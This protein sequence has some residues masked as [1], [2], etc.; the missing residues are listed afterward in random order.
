MKVWNVSEKEIYRAAVNTDV[1]IYNMRDNG[2]AKR[3][4]LKLADCKRWQRTSSS[5]FNR[6]RKVAVV[7]WHGHYHFMREIFRIN[8]DARIQTSWA[9]YKGL[10]SFLTDAPR[11]GK[12]NIGPPID[13]LYVEDACLCADRGDDYITSEKATENA[14][15]HTVMRAMDI[16]A[17]PHFIMTPEHYRSNGEC[18][19]DDPIEQD[20]LIRE[21][22]YIR[23]D[24]R[25]AS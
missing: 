22:G 11:T 1:R 25:R 3:F 23:E 12:R 4:T 24:F 5:Y 13:P 15:T 21:C 14:V 19:C 9:D 17:C 7:C 2:R 10:E 20:R 8:P 16:K 6:G 18:R